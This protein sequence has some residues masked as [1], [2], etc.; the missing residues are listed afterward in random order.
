MGNEKKLT[1]AKSLFA[2]FEK[3]V[4]IKVVVAIAVT[5][6]CFCSTGNEKGKGACVTCVFFWFTLASLFFILCAFKALLFLFAVVQNAVLLAIV[7]IEKSRGALKMV[8]ST[9]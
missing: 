2:V 8:F 9:M 4:G 5:V 1:N 7:T 3:V 6:V